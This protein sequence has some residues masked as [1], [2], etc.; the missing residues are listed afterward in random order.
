MDGCETSLL[1]PHRESTPDSLARSESL[2]R[3]HYP[4]P[5]WVLYYVLFTNISVNQLFF[6]NQWLCVW[7]SSKTVNTLERSFVLSR[8]CSMYLK[9]LSI[10]RRSQW[11]RGL[12]R[13]SAAAC[14]LRFWVRIPPGVWMFVCCKC[15]VFSGRDL[16]DELFAH[17]EESYWLWC[18]VV[19]DLEA[20]WMRRPWP[21]GGL[22]RQK[23]TVTHE[24]Q[25][26]S[27]NTEVPSCPL[28]LA[29]IST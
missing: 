3:L 7:D 16:C 14:L 10:I 19:C 24:T 29:F 20:L 27:V 8:Q 4:G 15:C 17:P 5:P 22:S 28:S 12:R 25:R 18:V 21:S 6:E 1:L 2:Y 23:Q 26:Y 9:P 13:R 11:P